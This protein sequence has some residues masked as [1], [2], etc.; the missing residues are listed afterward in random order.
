MVE[1]VQRVEADLQIAGL[2]GQRNPE[3]LA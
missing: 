1:D 2:A 3:I